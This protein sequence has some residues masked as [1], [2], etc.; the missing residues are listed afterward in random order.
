MWVLGFGAGFFA[1]FPSFFLLP[2]GDRRVGHREDAVTWLGSS[3]H[4]GFVGLRAVF[5]S[6]FSFFPL[7]VEY[8][9]E[10]RAGHWLGSTSVGHDHGGRL[11]SGDH[12][13]H[14][15]Q[16]DT[17]DTANQWSRPR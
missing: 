2:H 9:R 16:G 11:I 17:G 1:A 12:G 14:G 4:V 13:D 7:L 6:I 3:R 8:H 15:G 10:E 5:G